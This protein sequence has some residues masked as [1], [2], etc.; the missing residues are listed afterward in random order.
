MTDLSQL[1]LNNVG[2]VPSMGIS[3]QNVLPPNLR[4]SAP[5]SPV[6]QKPIKPFGSSSGSVVDYLNSQGKASDY[7]SRSALATQYGINGYTGSAAQ[8]TQ[9]LG[10]LRGGSQPVATA[11]GSMVSADPTGAV[12]SPSN[13]KVDVSGSVDSSV[14]TGNLGKSDVLKTQ[15]TYADYV[16]GL[17]QASQY[18]PQ[19]L[20]ALQAVQAAQAKDS[21]LKTNFY[22]GNNL[23]GATLDYAAGATARAQQLNNQSL[24]AGQQGLQVQELMRQGNIAAAGALVDAYQP[25]N[26]SPGTSLVNPVDGQQTYNGTGGYVGMQAIQTYNNLQQNFPDA[27][28]PAYDQN[29]TPE[30]N[31]QI[32]QQ[33]SSQ[34]PSFQSRSTIPVTLPGGGYALVNKNQVAGYNSDGTAI[35]VSPGQ[36]AQADAA[37]SSINKLT[38]DRSQLQSAITAADS[39]F[40]ILLNIANAAGVNNNAPVINELKQKVLNKT[41]QSQALAALNTLVPSLQAEYS[42]IIAR[43]GT[44][45][46]NTRKSA[47]AIINGTYSLGQLQAVYAVVQREG[48]NVLK[49]YDNEINRLTGSLNDIYKNPS[50]PG[51]TTTGTTNGSLYD[52]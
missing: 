17:A 12:T 45:D 26:V 25:V 37:K 42:R 19:Y 10:M 31:L 46:D 30:Q 5:T 28:I 52:F 33:L 23:P 47:Q 40:P 14:L 11:S 49:G 44:V 41:S 22:T 13:F 8:N 34:A 1:S 6:T 36:A 48:A 3:N 18:S 38:N 20:Q 50:K 21:E 7:S 27:Q 32:A 35:I 4:T 15:K 39:N 24:L 29:K 2:G 9:L 51:S 43:G 16:N